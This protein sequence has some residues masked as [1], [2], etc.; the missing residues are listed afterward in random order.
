MDHDQAGGLRFR[1][2]G[3]LE[4]IDSSG[5]QVD[6]G[7]SKPRL[8]LVHLLLSPNKTISTEALIDALWGDDPPPTARRSLQAH[9]A[10]LRSALGG[11]D[12]PLQSRPPGTPSLSVYSY[13]S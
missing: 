10:K 5:S 8:V 2:L 4:V 6:V 3:P 7:G 11:N 13:C 9:V 1:L 12:G